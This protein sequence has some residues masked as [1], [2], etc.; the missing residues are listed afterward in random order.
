[1]VQS[2]AWFDA[3]AASY[4]QRA[5]LPARHCQAIAQAVPDLVGAMTGDLLLELGAGSGSLGTWLAQPP[6]RYIGVDLSHHML[7]TFQR[8]LAPHHRGL[9]L[10]QADG[11]HPWPLGDGTVR[12]IFSSRALHWLDVAHVIRESYRVAR[13]DGCSLLVGRVQRPETSVPAI[14]Q[15]EMQCLLQRYGFAGRDGQRH[16]RQI[17]GAFQQRGAVLLDPVAVVGWSEVRTPWRS[18]VDWESKPGLGGLDV[19]AAVKRDILAELRLRAQAI[20]GDL[21]RE[22]AC[23]T[24]YVI[25]NVCL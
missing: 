10:V 15:H 2:S 13:P 1:M 3:Q 11:N 14:M 6:L 12:A 17:L 18:I 5:G 16:Q 4:D 21:H 23:E 22:V 20:F 19:T 24:A 8:R 25:Q 7:R 9:Q